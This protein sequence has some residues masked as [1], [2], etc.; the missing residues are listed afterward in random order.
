MQVTE[1]VYADDVSYG[2]W[3]NIWIPGGIQSEKVNEM[4]VV[5]KY[6]SYI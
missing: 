5:Q 1:S 4:V 2:W 6:S 3:M